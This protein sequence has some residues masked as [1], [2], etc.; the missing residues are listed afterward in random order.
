MN[1]EVRL[2]RTPTFDL[3]Y[4]LCRCEGF[5]VDSPGGRVGVVQEVHFRSRVDRPD[6]LAVRTGLLAPLLLIPVEEVAEV[7]LGDER[8]V[9]LRAPQ[10]NEKDLAGQL[11]NLL[12]RTPRLTSGAVKRRDGA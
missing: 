4:R 7:S 9:L 11:R 5:R 8:V 12:A 2:L 6:V 10:R 1:S 3:D